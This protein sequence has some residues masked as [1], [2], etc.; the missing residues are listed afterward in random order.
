[1]VPPGI[2]HQWRINRHPINPEEHID[3]IF[4]NTTDTISVFR[5][6]DAG[7][8]TF[9]TVHGSAVLTIECAA[10][11]YLFRFTHYG[12]EQRRVIR[13]GKQSYII[14]SIIQLFYISSL[15]ERPDQPGNITVFPRSGRMLLDSVRWERPENMIE[16][17]PLTYTVF[18]QDLLANTDGDRF[19]YYEVWVYCVIL[20][21]RN[22]LY[23][24]QNVTRQR[25]KTNFPECF[26]IT[27]WASNEAGTSDPAFHPSS[28]PC[29]CYIW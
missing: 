12:S 13:F 20:E 23:D 16:K 9:G 1:M 27:V 25:I 18:I 29:T 10:V 28:T 3:T 6:G 26:N 19:T 11:N 2:Q 7:L 14:P 15:A 8:D 22:G 21:L 4:I 24:H 5:I 17:V